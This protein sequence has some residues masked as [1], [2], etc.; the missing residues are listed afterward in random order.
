VLS[1][2]E[3]RHQYDSTGRAG[4]DDGQGGGGARPHGAGGDGAAAGPPH[5]RGLHS[6]TF[7]LNLS[8]FNVI[9]VHLGV[10]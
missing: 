8:A 9:G 1:S 6:S 10:V 5:G 7:R 3:K 2:D 4:S